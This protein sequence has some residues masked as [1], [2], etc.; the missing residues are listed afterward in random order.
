MYIA[1]AKRFAKAFIAGALG[2]FGF[3]LAGNDVHIL[4][5]DPRTYLGAT[6]AAVICGIVMAIDKA[7][8]WQDLPREP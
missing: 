1:V 8:N 2:A 3:L 4:L 6:S 7:I 5:T